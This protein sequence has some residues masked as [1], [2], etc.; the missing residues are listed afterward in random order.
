M[1]VLPS[2]TPGSGGLRTGDPQAGGSRAGAPA[3]DRPATGAPS[4]DGPRSAEPGPVGPPTGARTVTGTR[5]ATGV[6]ESGGSGAGGTKGAPGDDVDAPPAARSGGTGGDVGEPGGL[7]TGD[8]APGGRELRGARGGGSGSAAGDGG[9]SGAVSRRF[10]A[11]AALGTA[12]LSIAGSLLGLVRDQSLAR[13]F[14]AGSDTDAFLVAWTVPEIAATLLIEDGLAIALIPAFSMALARRARGVP[15]D[16]VRDLVKA[17]LPRLCL[18][19]AAVTALVAAGAPYLVRVLAPGLP[20]PRLAVD[21]TRLT[22]L[23][24]LAFG[25][26][27]YCSAALRAHRRF[28]APAA[29]YVAYNS[30]IVATMFL[31]GG[32]WGVRS[33]A[34]G[35][36]VGGC[37][38]V[39]VQLPSLWR[40]LASPAPAPAATGPAD[41]ERPVRLALIAAVLLFAL[42][43]QSQVLVERFLASSLPAGSISHLNYA[44]KVAQIPMTLSLMVCTVTFPVVARALADGDTRR[45]RARV[46]RDLVLASCVVL[47]G[48][49]AVIACAPQMIELLFQRGAFTAADSA[50]T[51]NVMRVYALG[52]LG[53]TLVGALVR[54]YFSAGRPSW[55]PLGVMAAGVVVTSLIGAV[56]VGRWGVAGIAAANAFGITVTA[57]LLLTGLRTARPGDTG[58]LTLGV[59]GVL[60]RLSRPVLAS[61]LAVAAGTS[62][63][64]LFDSPVAALAAGC[65]AVAAVFVP[66]ALSVPVARRSVSVSA[67]RSVRTV[68]RKLTHGRSR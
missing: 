60:G 12:V 68:T 3:S 19:F 44:Q 65:P 31:L 41:E 11:R 18:A 27:G 9:A 56:T 34:V 25:L 52:L 53:Q 24:L 7:R 2:Q 48:M 50:A 59:R 40:R 32:E 8:P 51:A 33:A 64:S 66:L 14:G 38:M 1:T 17:T 35:V 42:C 30:G 36:A 49:C 62:A 63:A 6:P 15:G 55:Y 37:L 21:C 5:T 58:G 13:L 26:A 22:A 57:V 67:L 61:V 47:A 45:A 54:C 20:D 16:P 10:L 39:A 28:F 4:A 29:I 23:S 43:R 46:E